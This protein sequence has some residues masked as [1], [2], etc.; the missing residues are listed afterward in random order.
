MGGGV[1]KDEFAKVQQDLNNANQSRAE[2]TAQLEE[3][4][5]LFQLSMTH[6][7]AREDELV[8]RDKLAQKELLAYKQKLAKAESDAL[9]AKRAAA[10]DKVEYEK[11]VR[12]LET[13][14]QKLRNDLAESVRRHQA[15]TKELAD[16][17]EAWEKERRETAL[18]IKGL[19]DKLAS[20]M[21]KADELMADLEKERDDRKEMEAGYQ[22]KLIKKEDETRKAIE[23]QDAKWE[24]RIDRWMGVVPATAEVGEPLSAVDGIAKGMEKPKTGKLLWQM[25][26]ERQAANALRSSPIVS[27]SASPSMQI[28]SFSQLLTD[29]F[30]P[31]IL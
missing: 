2:T 8:A 16:T 23:R 15:I 31:L 12:T 22:A 18:I 3:L 26:Q 28:G 20:L 9:I 25:V 27:R 6:N 13:E 30:W 19:E 14:N 29:T 1:N 17:K 21:V 5:K 11:R 7:K 24:A 10:V 4:R